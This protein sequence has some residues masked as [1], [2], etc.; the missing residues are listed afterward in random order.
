MPPYAKSNSLVHSTGVTRRLK[1]TDRR[2]WEGVLAVL[3]VASVA[4]CGDDGSTRPARAT[5]GGPSL[6]QQVAQAKQQVYNHCVAN[7]EVAGSIP[8]DQLVRAVRALQHLYRQAP[9]TPYVGTGRLAVNEALRKAQ[10]QLESCDGPLFMEVRRFLE[11][12]TKGQ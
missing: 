7:A 10:A 6:L 4:G 9:N 11:E 3:I 12:Q 1:L 2:V 8:R 5:S